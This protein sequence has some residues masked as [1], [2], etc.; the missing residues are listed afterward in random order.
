MDSN[1]DHSGHEEAIAPVRPPF[2]TAESTAHGAHDEAA[3]AGGVYA[4]RSG[5]AS[6]RP[7]SRF[8]P[9]IVAVAGAVLVAVAIGVFFVLPKWMSSA[10]PEPAPAASAAAPEPAEPPKPKLTEAQIAALSAQTED[11]LAQLLTQQQRLKEM[12]AESWGGE[13]WAR[14][15]QASKSGD[16]AYLAKSFQDSVA[17]YQQALDLGKAL[18]ERSSEITHR[19]LTAGQQALEVGN[20]E[21]AIQQFDLVLGVEP[22]NEEAKAGRARAEKLPQVL[23]LA[24]R[25]D[26]LRDQGQLP[27]AADA[28]RQAL[29]V[30]GAWKPAAD[31]L[32]Q[33]ERQIADQKF[34]ALMSK[35][36]TA[37]S[38]GSYEDAENGFKAALAMRPGSGEA[39]DG[40]VQA[41]QKLA[42]DKI[43]LA[44]T[45]GAAFERRE[46][47]DR[48]I[49]QYEQA[50][51]ED[52]TLQFAKEGLERSRSRA[53]LDAKLS[54]LIE[55]PTLLFREDVLEGARG[56]LEQ[57]RAIPD[58]GSRLNQQIERLD[59][60]I[61]QATTPVTVELRSDAQTEVTLY[62]V[63]KLGA[64]AA[65]QVELRPG[66]YT[67]IG[68]RDGYR[69][70][71]ETFTVLPGKAPEPVSVVCSETI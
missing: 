3:Y 15:E 5:G 67:V 11:L 30:D 62:R 65:K 46:L 34:E 52:S 2:A 7:G 51:A 70:V 69:D 19:A 14:Y 39:K 32:A 17:S 23:D 10:A 16:D 33:V 54:H 48:A 68:S 42:L 22:D 8:G 55:N 60:L 28:Y 18:L 31:A 53:G 44:Q 21:L 26:E 61:A 12:S 66:Q 29:A 38:G 40:L 71:R 37:L 50:L 41:R 45:R 24:H 4:D 20:S 47:W 63:G 1:T 57:A 6:A 56:V 36:F 49:E 25:G 58:P 27:E 43:S 35:A 9:A 64:F 13:D 59:T